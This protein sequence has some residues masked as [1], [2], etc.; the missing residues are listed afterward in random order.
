MKRLRNLLLA[1]IGVA[2]VAALSSCSCRPLDSLKNRLNPDGQTEK[3]DFA[4]RRGGKFGE[5]EKRELNPEKDAA[6]M[7]ITFGDWGEATDAETVADDSDLVAEASEIGGNGDLKVTLLWDFPGD[8]DLH[9]EQPNGK[10]IYF[11]NKNDSQTGGSLDVD[12]R[13]GG[14]GSAENIFW[15]NAPQGTYRVWIHYYGPSKN[16]GQTGSGTCNVVLM[17]KGQQARTFQTNMSSLGEKASIVT[18]DVN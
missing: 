17:R 15:E 10:Q 7:A 3:D 9:V 1:F 11:M 2:T 16:S 5:Y 4:D 14:A 12:N 6:K 13:I 8:I 18:F